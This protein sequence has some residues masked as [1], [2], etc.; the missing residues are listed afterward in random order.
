VAR[1]FDGIHRP[2]RIMQQPHS[3]WSPRGS[4]RWNLRVVTQPVTHSS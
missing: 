2:C 4:R 1:K 3:P